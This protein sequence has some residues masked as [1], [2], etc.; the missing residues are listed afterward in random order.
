MK[1]YDQLEVMPIF[2]AFLMIMW[3][4]GGMIVLNEISYYT[5][6]QLFGIFLSICISCAGIKVLT[7]KIKKQRQASRHRVSDT[8]SL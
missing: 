1:E 4:L 8:H 5:A 3:M 6:I 7:L 2:Q